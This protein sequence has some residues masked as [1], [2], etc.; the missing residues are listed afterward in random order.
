MPKKGLARVILSLVL[1]YFS[2]WKIISYRKYRKAISSCRRTWLAR[3]AYMFYGIVTEITLI[4]HF[5]WMQRIN[6]WSCQSTTPVCVCVRACDGCALQLRNWK[7]YYMCKHPHIWRWKQ[8][9]WNRIAFVMATI[10]LW[11]CRAYERELCKERNRSQQ[12]TGRIRAAHDWLWVCA[13]KRL[14]AVVDKWS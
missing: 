13:A 14:A 5:Q 9:A 2:N 10:V 8:A 6:T 7:A 11:K 12:E 3:N 1:I 4:T